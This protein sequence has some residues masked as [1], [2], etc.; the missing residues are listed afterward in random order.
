VHHVKVTKELPNLFDYFGYNRPSGQ[1]IIGWKKMY[2]RTPPV[3][4][5]CPNCDIAFY[6]ASSSSSSTGTGGSMSRMTLVNDKLYTIPERHTLQVIDI[7][8][9]PQPQ[10]GTRIMAG[11]DLETIFP[12]QNKLFLGSQVGVFIYDLTDPANPQ[13]AGTFTHGRACDPV[14]ADADYAYVTLHEGT[15]CGG[16]ANELD[17]I[18]I[19]N[20]SNPVLATTIP[21]TKPMGLSKDGDL[22]FVCDNPGVK[23]FN[24]SSPGALQLTSTLDVGN[25]YDV[26]TSNHRLVVMSDKGLYQFDYSQSGIPLLSML[27]LNSIH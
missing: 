25:A 5:S 27:P 2:S 19:K 23:V 10:I 24:A 9:A 8:N 12:F 17:V 11:V 21:M 15:Q 7:K 26:I 13:A 18:N 16:A 4:A 20:L 22:L 6:A 3:P 14:V 1:V